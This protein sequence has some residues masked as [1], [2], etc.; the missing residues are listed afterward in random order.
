MAKDK[1]TTKE[2]QITRNFMNFPVDTS[3]TKQKSYT[4]TYV[5]LNILHWFLSRKGKLKQNFTEGFGD[6]YVL[7]C[8][9]VLTEQFRH[10]KTLK[11]ARVRIKWVEFNGGLSNHRGS[12]G[13][14]PGSQGTREFLRNKVR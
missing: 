1:E 9:R 6:E 4:G 2:R 8:D 12:S 13:Q 7:C 5:E 14:Q 3:N 11:F 10:G